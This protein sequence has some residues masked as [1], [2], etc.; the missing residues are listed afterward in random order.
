MRRGFYASTEFS[1][2]VAGLA[3]IVMAWAANLLGVFSGGTGD[4]HGGM[5]IYFWFLF[6]LQGIAFAAVGA[7]YDHHR[8]LMSDPA[9]AKRYLVGYL[10]ILDGAIHL[11]AFNEHLISST[12]A[13]LFFEVV[14]P[15]QIILG[16]LIPHLS[17]RFDVAW[18][19]FTLFLIAAYVVTRT[20][21]I[22]PIGEVEAVDPLGLISKAVET[23]TGAAL[24]SLMWA[25]RV[26]RANLPSAS[27][28]D[29]P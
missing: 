10:F 20:V 14:S 11:L 2:L 1:F 5:D 18:L 12:Y 29:G 26:G 25:R 13:V 19:L 27:P 24:V 17:S 8:R 7:A 9:F 28:T 4:S 3:I 16:V 22:W 21:A 15:V 6:M 23:A